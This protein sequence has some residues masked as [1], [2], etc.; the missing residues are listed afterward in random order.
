MERVSM[1][2]SRRIITK[3]T[4]V[5]MVIVFL[6]GCKPLMD[7]FKKETVTKEKKVSVSMTKKIDKGPVLLNIDGKPA[8]TE[9]EFNK[10][11]TQMLQVN[12]YFRGA[13][14]DSLPAPLKRKFFDELVKQELIIAWAEKNNID[15]EQEFKKSFE[16]MKKLV[17]RSLLV[18]RF[19]TKL[20]ENIKISDKELKD[21]YEKNKEKF[22]KEPGGVLVEGISFDDD[23]NA[24][25]FLNKVKGKKSQFKKIAKAENKDAFKSFGR[26]EDNQVGFG[27]NIPKKIKEKAL[28]LKNLPA[29]A[30]VQ[31]EGKVWVICASD[32]KDTQ[33]FQLDEIKEQLEGML[34]NNKFREILNKKVDNLKDK[35]TLDINEDYF[36]MPSEESEQEEQ[37]AAPASAA[38]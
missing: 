27:V 5:V 20:F 31:A 13:S 23:I 14:I 17:K 37:K 26:I 15:D 9:S 36:Q 1:Y 11:L 35:F 33:Y 3:M 18:Q 30:K 16:E 29:V 19:E 25:A 24:T 38:V 2:S 7:L 8:I 28:S 22:V 32:K 10:H 4:V 21:H 6:G 34:K 12:P